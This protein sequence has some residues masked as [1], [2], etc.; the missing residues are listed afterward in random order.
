MKIKIP[1][2]IKENDTIGITAPSFGCATEPYITKF[3][4]AKKILEDKG[5]KI[6]AGETVKINVVGKVDALN[7]ESITNKLKSHKMKIKLKDYRHFIH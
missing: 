3:K 5:F 2:F 1:P 7:T 6:K 4:T